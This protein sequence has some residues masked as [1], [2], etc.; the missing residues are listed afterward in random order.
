MRRQHAQ[1]ASVQK[2]VDR[3]LWQGEPRYPS[4]GRCRPQVRGGA[5]PHVLALTHPPLHHVS[6]HGAHEAVG[7]RVLSCCHRV[8]TF[9]VRAGLRPSSSVCGF[10]V[11]RANALSLCT[12]ALWSMSSS[13]LGWV[14]N[15]AICTVSLRAL[16]VRRSSWTSTSTTTLGSATNTQRASRV[17][18][19]ECPPN[20]RGWGASERVTCLHVDRRLELRTG[21]TARCSRRAASSWKMR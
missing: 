12:T 18:V 15:M 16:T 1:P 3:V 7:G 9:P 5:E 8:T 11:H 4:P 21:R 2:L 10:A 14:L 20:L 6:L 13:T 17:S 19:G